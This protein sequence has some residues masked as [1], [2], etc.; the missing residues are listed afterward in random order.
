M[1]FLLCF[2]LLYT[3]KRKVQSARRDMPAIRSKG[4]TS[5]CQLITDPAG[6]SVIKSSANSHA[7]IVIKLHFFIFSKKISIIKKSFREISLDWKYSIH[8]N[9]SKICRQAWQ[10]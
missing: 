4:G 5:R 3:R 8:I 7:F 9:I 1:L 6:Y 2:A 10:L